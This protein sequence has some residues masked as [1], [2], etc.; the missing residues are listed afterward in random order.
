LQDI[1][2]SYVKTLRLWRE[3]LLANAAA[4]GELGYD[5]PFRRVWTLYLA[6][7]EAGFAERRIRDVQLVLAKQRTRLEGLGGGRT[8][9][10]GERHEPLLAGQ[11]G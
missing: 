4:L 6:Y 5:E 3:R 9:G 11:T 7:C 1:T 2:S 10:G 8:P